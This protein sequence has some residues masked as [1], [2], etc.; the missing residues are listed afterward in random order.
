MNP[1][2]FKTKYDA[3]LATESGRHANEIGEILYDHSEKIGT[4]NAAALQDVRHYLE[5]LACKEVENSLPDWLAV[6]P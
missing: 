5:I 4:S 6:K 2:D 3:F 1:L